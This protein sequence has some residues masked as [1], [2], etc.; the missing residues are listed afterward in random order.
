MTAG[1]GELFEC[2]RPTN[3]SS[4][5]PKKSRP[6]DVT[7]TKSTRPRWNLF[8]PAIHP[9]PGAGA[10]DV[11][12]GTGKVRTRPRSRWTVVMHFGGPPSYWMDS[13]RQSDFPALPD[14]V[15]VDVAV[16]G[17]GI[18]GITTALLLKC[19][20]FSVALVEAR[21]VAEQITGYTTAKVTSQHKLIYS[22]L[23]RNAGNEVARL[24]GQ[25]QQAALR[26]VGELID[27]LRIDCGFERAPAYTYCTDAAHADVIRREAELAR[28]LGLPAH[29][30]TDTEL[31]FPVAAAVRFDQQARFHPRKYLLG[32][33][34]QIPGSGSHVFERSRVT[35]LGKGRL[36]KAGKAELAAEQTVITT[37]LP[38]VDRSG[39]FALAHPYAH[40]ALAAVIEEHDAFKGMYINTETP[41]R[42][43]RIHHETDRA[44][45]I[46]T[47]AKFKVGEADTLAEVNQLENW[48]RQ[49][50]AVREVLGA[51]WNQDFHTVDD[52][53]Y[54]GRV[55]TR[56]S[57]LWTATGFS[58]WGM[59][60]GTLAAM[61]LR[62]RIQGTSRPWNRIYDARR[63]NLREAG[64]RIAKENLAIARKW[65]GGRLRVR[66]D[67][68]AE[69]L[70]PGEAAVVRSGRHAVAA[71]RTDDGVLHRVSAN[72]THMGC[73]VQWNPLAGSWDCPCHGSRFAPDGKVL[74][75]PATQALAPVPPE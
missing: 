37:G 8:P 68:R 23:A 63:R 21:R 57:H 22:A 43:V 5:T 55:G 18:A 14:G 33:V 20:G 41:T 28:Q 65:F 26:T 29:F 59:T 16:V 3:G 27:E 66:D 75:G 70:S 9:P 49:H 17:A 34:D 53:P 72:C 13:S 25:S 32:L 12:G 44:I 60:G 7:G 50:F 10:T 48:T 47:G 39:H 71:H 11:P 62:D 2:G 19:A 56:R 40:V 42:S 74:C 64:P 6:D 1:T 24:Y 4:A 38:I 67:R 54:I 58:A 69:Q 35:D 46:A 52:R 73:R 36:L 30:T 51:W 15:R 31:P 61:I 45:L